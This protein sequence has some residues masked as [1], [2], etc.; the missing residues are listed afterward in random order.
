MQGTSPIRS[1][2]FLIATDIGQMAVRGHFVE[3]GQELQRRG[4]RVALVSSISGK[5]SAAKAGLQVY[6][7]PGPRPVKFRDFRFLMKIIS[8]HKPDCAIANFGAVNVFA[9][10]NWIRR[11]PVRM[12]W[13]H[14][15]STQ[16]DLDSVLSKSRMRLLR[17]RKSLVYATATHI[18]ANSRAAS[19]DLQRT[20][21]V[22]AGKCAVHTLSLTDPLAG[23][24]I[25]PLGRGALQVICVGRFSPSKGQATLVRALAKLKDQTNWT[26]VLVGDGPEK[27][28]VEKLAQ[29]LGVANRCGFAGV[30]SHGEVLNQMRNSAISVVPSLVEAYGYVALESMAI[31]LPVIASNTGG[32]AETVRDGIDGFLVPPAQAEALSGKLALLL[33]D[34]ALRAR[35]GANARERFLAKFERSHVIT[36]QADLLERLTRQN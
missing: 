18:V 19:E 14:T 7:W 36:K 31:G 29:E 27:S 4:H 3:L 25:R 1:R 35:M 26:A 12:V 17:W 30:C 21:H 32:L 22:P 16:I 5:A 24:T 15:L 8:Q 33:Q 20:F 9:L 13:Y 23:Q 28:A 10:A 2:S 6:F 11:V 34:S